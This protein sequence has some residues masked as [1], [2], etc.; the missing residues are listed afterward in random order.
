MIY[1]FADV[2]NYGKPLYVHSAVRIAPFGMGAALTTKPRR[3][4]TKQ[5]VTVGEVIQKV[6]EFKTKPLSRQA[7]FQN[8]VIKEVVEDLST[9]TT[10]SLGE[11]K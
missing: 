3:T 2:G 1:K 11:G 4:P 10:N 6:S 5:G 9:L 7:Q 8:Q